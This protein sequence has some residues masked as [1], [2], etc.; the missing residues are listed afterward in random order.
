MIQKFAFKYSLVVHPLSLKDS[1]CLPVC[2]ILGLEYVDRQ[3]KGWSTQKYGQGEMW[4]I[5]HLQ[6]DVAGQLHFSGL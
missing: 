6:L 3:S 5:P 2:L 4:V 1:C